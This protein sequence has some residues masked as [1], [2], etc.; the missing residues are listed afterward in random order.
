VI[1][2]GGDIDANLTR[3]QLAIVETSEIMR[4]YF[5]EAGL[6]IRP[7]DKGNYLADTID[8]FGGLAPAADFIAASGKRGI[9]DLYLT[10]R[11]AED[12]HVV[13]LQPEGGRAFISYDGVKRCVDDEAVEI[14]DLLIGKEILRRGLIF[15][16]DR[17]RLASWYDLSDLSAEFVCRR[18]SQRQQFT[19]AN[20]KM[21]DEP[22]WY[23]ALAE[24]VYQCYT[25][26]SHLTILALNHLRQTSTQ[27][28]QYLPEIEV[29][30]FPTEGEK[31]EI[32]IACQVDNRLVIGEC[33]TEE[34]KP[35]HTRKYEALA[36]AL[37]RRPDRVVFATSRQE[38]SEA[39]RL[40]AN[41]IQGSSILTRGDLFK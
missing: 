37:R 4:Q 17:C 39:F 7:S 34:L 3:P 8:R 30:N 23:Y 15:L 21:P 33:K 12:G 20:W 10:T 19:K 11:S 27:S 1:T 22:R 31:H 9:L 29:L 16:C 35:S 40:K 5:A 36:N 14:I 13:Y 6:E 41:E 24:T 26:D 38:V 25:H 28:F 2:F 18:C 32:D